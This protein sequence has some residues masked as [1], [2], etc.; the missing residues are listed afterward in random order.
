MTWFPGKGA[1][2]TEPSM[3]QG[4]AAFRP[5]RKREQKTFQD[6]E[7]KKSTA[8]MSLLVLLEVKGEEGH[9]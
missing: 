7:G 4:A 1:P 3:E 2:R 6:Q 8:R 9:C 5:D